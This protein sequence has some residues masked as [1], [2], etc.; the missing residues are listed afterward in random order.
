MQIS[1]RKFLQIESNNILKSDQVGFI[2]GMQVFFNIHKSINWYTILTN[3]KI[4]PYAYFNGCR[5]SLWQNSTSI[6][7]KSTANIIFNVEILTAFP[8]KSGTSQGHPFSPLLFNVVLE[9]LATEIREEKETK[10][11]QIGREVK[12]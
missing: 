2:S 5:E 11:M 9:I 10:Q 8:L 12:L 1:L 3:W 7:V 4:K 6:Y